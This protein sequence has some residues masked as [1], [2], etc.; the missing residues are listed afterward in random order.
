MTSLATTFDPSFAAEERE[1]VRDLL[2]RAA[3]AL[4]RILGPAA[5]GAWTLR[6]V[7][8]AMRDSNVPKFLADD[9]PLFAAIVQDLFPGV[10]IPS[11]DY[12]ELQV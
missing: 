2:S 7:S 3:P 8:R 4:E 11:N 10:S 5:P 6:K 9:L 1:R 12:G